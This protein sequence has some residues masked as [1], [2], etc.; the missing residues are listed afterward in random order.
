M[1]Y[2]MLLKVC[3]LNSPVWGLR[4]CRN[5]VFLVILPQPVSFKSYSGNIFDRF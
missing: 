1:E 4:F 5:G 2:M 3:V